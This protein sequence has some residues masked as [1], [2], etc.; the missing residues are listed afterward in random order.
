MFYAFLADLLSAVHFGYVAFVVGGLLLI[1]I[2]IGRRWGWIRNVWFRVVHLG[3]ILIVALESLVGIMCPLTDW[4][5]D[6]RQLAGQ[7]LEGDSFVANLLGH[8][9]WFNELPLNH[10]VFTAGY[11]SFAALVVM[12]F[13]IAPPRRRSQGPVSLGVDRGLFAT[14]LLGTAGFIFVY[15]ALCMNQFK[16]ILDRKAEARYR[17]AL[18]EIGTNNGAA[19]RPTKEN[20][21]PVYLLAFC[22]I[23]FV[24]LALLC[25]ALR[26]E[27]GAMNGERRTEN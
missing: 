20:R 13:V 22:G 17:E 9:M 4:E 2:G 10:W 23:D 14:A 16:D 12:T 24:G 25:W 1:L 19:D 26:P 27:K 7:P 21:L 11:V 5:K 6:L 15:T 3:M 8:I 18:V